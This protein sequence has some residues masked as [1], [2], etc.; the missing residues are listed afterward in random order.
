MPL[1][2]QFRGRLVIGTADASSTIYRLSRHAIA[3]M[4]GTNRDTR[5]DAQ[6]LF[7]GADC[8]ALLACR[9]RTVRIPE[10]EW[11]IL[12]ATIPHAHADT[13]GQDVR[14][15]L[16]AAARMG[17]VSTLT[18]VALHELAADGDAP[19]TAPDH[20]PSTLFE[21]DNPETARRA[22]HDEKVLRDRQ[23]RASRLPQFPKR[24]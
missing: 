8:V 1:V 19:P 23:R 18:F 22:E 5:P 16:R 12:Q 10:A 15:A 2:K 3:C 21:P 4:S 7:S 20:R 14:G 9:A 11:I 6:R 24:S 17:A 13:I